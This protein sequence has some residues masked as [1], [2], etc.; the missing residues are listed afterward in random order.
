M[1]PANPLG[2]A[3]D[4]YLGPPLPT[5]SCSAWCL[6]ESQAII[7]LLFSLIHISINLSIYKPIIVF[8][9]VFFEK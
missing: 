8:A 3:I 9:Y 1:S 5:H 7:F 6:Y 2:S 4:S